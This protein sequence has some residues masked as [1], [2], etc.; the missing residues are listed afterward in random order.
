MQLLLPVL[1]SVAAKSQV[2]VTGPTCVTPGITCQYDIAAN[3]TATATMQVCASGGTV[4]VANSSCTGNGTPQSRVFISWNA[5]ASN[6]SVTITSSLGNA[7]LN[8]QIAAALQPGIIDSTILVQ[9][10]SYNAIPATISCGLASGGNCSPSYSY[11]WQQSTDAMQWTNV[12]GA[13][14][15]Q[16]SFSSGLQQTTYYRRKVTETV[17]GTIGYSNMAVVYVAPATTGSN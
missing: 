5:N 7:T 9:S 3:W 17:S 13:T 6:P 10:V 2:T 4:I 12:T 16:V 8:V 15:T 11:T 1:I 14:N